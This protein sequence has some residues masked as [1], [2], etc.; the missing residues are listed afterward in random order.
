MFY[1]RWK[2][3]FAWS[4]LGTSPTLFSFFICTIWTHFFISSQSPFFTPIL[5]RIIF[6]IFPP[7]LPKALD[8]L[9]FLTPPPI[10]FLIP[11]FYLHPFPI[12]SDLRSVLSLFFSILSSVFLCFYRRGVLWFLSRNLVSSLTHTYF[13]SQ[14]FLSGFWSSEGEVLGIPP[15]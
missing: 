2:Y 6:L 15:T 5:L 4:T 3:C 9:P 11:H 12:L 13:S 14:V 7:F 1:S 10:F 8:L